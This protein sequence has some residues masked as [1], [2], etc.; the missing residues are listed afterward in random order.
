ML[1]AIHSAD[2]QLS[3]L[4]DFRQEVY[5]RLGKGRDALFDLMD[6]NLCTRSIES[7]AE[8]S[9]S[10]V[11]RRGWPSTYE[12]VQDGEVPGKELMPLYCAQMSGELRPVLAGDHTAWP[13]PQA[14]TLADRTI[15]H[16]PTSVPGNRPITIGH[17]YSTLAW[18]PDESGSWAL[19]LLHERIG[20]AESP[21]TKAAAQLREVC[22][23]LPKE[24]PPVA[25][26]DS[27][28][29]CAPFVLATADI[30]AVKV[31]RLRPNMCL[32]AP[33]PEYSGRGRPREHGDK[34]KL[35]DATTWPQADDTLEVEEPELGPVRVQLWLGLHLRKAKGQTLSLIRIE[36]LN[37]KGTR[38][39]P[40]G[41][42]LG[43]LGEEAPSLPEDWRLYL[44][45]FAVDHW[46][47]FAKQRLHWTEPQLGTPER[48]QT[49]SNLVVLMTWQLFLG[50]GVLED[51]PLPWQA[52]VKKMTPGRACQAWGSLLAR[53]GTPAQ[54]PK[55]RAKSPGWP[56]GRVRKRRDVHPVVKKAN[57]RRKTTAT[58]A[59]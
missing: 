55:P 12:A 52:T 4:L 36:R 27:E 43:W 44:R 13:G 42:W 50:R 46:Y 14:R 32:W 25:L 5:D 18:V 28:Y 21:I 45:R 47:R 19:P 10:P 53:I 6:A 16:Q 54:V 31:M 35:S 33:P 15:E 24:R 41:L 8:L 39:D 58:T 23:A 34:F 20:T 40:K 37:A 11:F 9:L 1:G 38:R 49:W 22:E 7:L 51:K 56:K 48:S 26:Y 57:K 59:D 30:A 2:G 29:G 3:R 17:G